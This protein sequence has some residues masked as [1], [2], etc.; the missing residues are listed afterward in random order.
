MFAGSGFP[1]CDRLP[2]CATVR[3][4][5]YLAVPIANIA[6]TVMFEGFEAPDM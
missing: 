2:P 3:D 5:D 6:K 4:A 1:G